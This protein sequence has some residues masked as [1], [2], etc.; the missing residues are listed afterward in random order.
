MVGTDIDD[1]SLS[2]AERNISS[3]RL[4][5]RIRLLKAKTDSLLA[6]ALSTTSDTSVEL[7]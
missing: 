5:D 1:H 6:E 4:N 3:N 7:P 2:F